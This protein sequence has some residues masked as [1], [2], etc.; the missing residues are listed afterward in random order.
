MKN[1]EEIKKIVK[2][3]IEQSNKIKDF[4][5]IEVEKAVMSIRGVDKRTVSTWF[6]ALVQLEYLIQSGHDSIGRP[7]YQFNFQK[8]KLY[9]F[10]LE[11]AHTQNLEVSE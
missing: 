7:F 2:T 1:E 11:R 8:V 4:K 6:N 5:K 9:E 3:L 10:E